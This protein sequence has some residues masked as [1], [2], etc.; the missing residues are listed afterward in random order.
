LKTQTFTSYQKLIIAILAFSQ[1][2][3]ILDFMVLS[4]L[5][6]I[7]LDELSITTQQFG[8]VV[9]AYAFS[10]GAA[11]LLAAG[12]ADRF[13][14]KKLLLFFYSGFILGTLFCGLAPNYHFLLIARIITG[15]FGGVIG[16]IVYAI[17]TDLFVLE[18]RGR[19][20]GFVQMA[21]A[22]SQIL[23]IPIGLYLANHLG[24]HSPFL[25]IVGLSLV[26]GIIIMIYMKPVNEHL[27]LQTK[28]NA[29]VH[30]A[31]TLSNKRYLRGFSATTLLATGGFML[32]P[33]GAA[34][35]VNNLGIS[36]D[37]L[38]MVYLVTGIFTMVSGP[39]SGKLSDKYGKFRMFTIGSLLA[40]GL[41]LLYTNL[42][43]TPLWMVIAINVILFLGITLRMISSQ[44]LLTAIPEPKDRGA[45]MG[46]NSSVMQISG[47]FAAAL[48]GVI[49]VQ[50]EDG[51][52]LRYPL[53]GL[54]VTASILIT[55]ALMYF[56]NKMV[57][58]KKKAETAKESES[59][60]V[61][62]PVVKS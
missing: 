55:I 47:G 25:L 8:M 59:V 29:F 40:A 56:I 39:L 23:G 43:V 24:W 30:M 21:F 28:Q 45:F 54:V 44:A 33:F 57:F 48:A 31:K 3:V 15:I 6:A 12:F 10:A 13:D 37:M 14:R 58:A 42:D 62:V 46:I 5:S 18:K 17:I 52:L 9:S 36:I 34:F 26:V 27:K 50:G 11:G 51:K 2:T 60:L 4:P 19:V 16:S 61:D 22:A 38:P 49:V 41:I 32:M 1:F 35:A 20:M 53:L 7:L